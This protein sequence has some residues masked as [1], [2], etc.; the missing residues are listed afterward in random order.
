MGGP[1]TAATNC[2]RVI[3]THI[4][5]DEPFFT[6]RVDGEETDRQTTAA[7]LSLKEGE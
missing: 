2:A 4:F 6:I 3:E 5:D 7:R 1:N